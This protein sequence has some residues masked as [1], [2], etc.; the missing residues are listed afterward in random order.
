MSI[1]KMFPMM[2]VA[3]ALLA[4]S[5]AFAADAP[6]MAAS[7]D[8]FVAALQAPSGEVAEELPALDAT[9]NRTFKHGTNCYSLG[10]ACRPCT[11]S[12]GAR[13]YNSCEATSCVYNGTRHTHYT[14]CLGCALNCAN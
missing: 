9:Q 2:V 4:S 8:E 12:T 10:I 7:D 3:F 14:N 5:A 6:A 13:G 11:L 1:R